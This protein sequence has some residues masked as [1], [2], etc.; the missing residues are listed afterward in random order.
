VLLTYFSSSF[1]KIKELGLIFDWVL[2]T[3][4]IEI[5]FGTKSKIY[6]D[7]AS[8]EPGGLYPVERAN[9]G[10]PPR[11]RREGLVV[12]LHGKPLNVPSFNVVLQGISRYSVFLP[13]E[14]PGCTINKLMLSS[15]HPR[16]TVVEVFPK[17]EMRKNSKESFA[18]VHKNG[19]LNNRTG[20]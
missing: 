4:L 3:K 1:I 13:R 5:C 17:P 18:E 9:V 10:L 20:V 14:A 16:P 7:S 19:N 12:V 8:F 15:G 11:S 6:S 2:G